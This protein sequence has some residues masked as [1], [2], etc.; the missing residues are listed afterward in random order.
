MF[1]TRCELEGTVTP[2]PRITLIVTTAMVTFLAVSWSDDH[3]L[4]PGVTWNH[5][6]RPVRGV[7]CTESTDGARAGDAQSGNKVVKGL[8]ASEGIKRR[9]RG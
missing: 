7:R 5:G 8:F 4:W 3:R 1:H 9:F 6:I 2:S